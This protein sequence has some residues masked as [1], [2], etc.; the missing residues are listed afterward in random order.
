MLAAKRKE[1]D[2]VT[3]RGKTCHRKLQDPDRFVTIVRILL[4]VLVK[5]PSATVA[6]WM[7]G[8]SELEPAGSMTDARR[9]C[10]LLPD[11]HHI[12]R[13]TSASP[14]TVKNVLGSLSTRTDESSV[15][16]LLGVGVD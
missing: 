3:I 2:R 12:G 14:M 1:R 16:Q 9:S 13:P 11:A 4:H 8:T 6:C 7:S 15:K 10:G 5:M